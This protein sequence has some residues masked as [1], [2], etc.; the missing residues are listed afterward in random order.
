MPCGGVLAGFL[1]GGA[2]PTLEA[3]RST[4]NC[5]RALYNS[6]MRIRMHTITLFTCTL[7]QLLRIQMQCRDFRKNI[8][9]CNLVKQTLR[10]TTLG[11]IMRHYTGCYFRDFTRMHMQHETMEAQSLITETRSIISDHGY[12]SVSDVQVQNNAQ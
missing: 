12:N 8:K 1:G 5:A 11:W 4:A 10:K 9:M 2:L 3:S 6:D 7:L